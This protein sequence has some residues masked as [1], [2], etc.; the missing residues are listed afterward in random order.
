MM[1]PAGGGFTGFALGGAPTLGVN[2]SNAGEYGQKEMSF[3]PI[4]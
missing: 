3:K 2:T 4:N 1:N